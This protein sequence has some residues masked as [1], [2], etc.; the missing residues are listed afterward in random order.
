MSR[1]RVKVAAVSKRLPEGALRQTPAAE[2][3]PAPAQ[4]PAQTQTL[5]QAPA[6]PLKKAVGRPKKAPGTKAK[7][8]TVTLWPHELEALEQ[9]R[10]KINDGLPAEVSRSDLARLAF[11][12]L[13]EMQPAGAREALA[14]LRK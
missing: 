13:L 4:T 6:S 10:A 2:E 12:L 14:R 11:S 1:Q 5:V 9:L 3:A 7:G 8:V